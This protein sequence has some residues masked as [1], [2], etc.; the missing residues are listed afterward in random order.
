MAHNSL[1][2][3]SVSLPPHFRFASLV[4]RVLGVNA[5]DVRSVTLIDPNVPAEEA[6][7]TFVVQLED[8]ALAAALGETREW[9][10]S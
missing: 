8:T 4:M 2:H 10:D 3:T 1:N 5:C 7:V 9:S 6:D